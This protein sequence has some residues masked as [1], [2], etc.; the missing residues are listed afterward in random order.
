MTIVTNRSTL[1]SRISALFPKLSNSR[2]KLAR[3]VLD[4][5]LSVAF[6]SATE[7]GEQV[8]VS[9][10]TVVRFCQILGYEGYP[11]LQL[12]V[13]AGIP[14]YLRAVQRL[15]RG[16]GKVNQDELINRVFD[17][18]SQNI[19]RTAG[20]LSADRFEAAVVALSKASDIL[21]VGS[22]LS[23]APV[24]YLSHSLN[25]M[26]L[27]ARA[28]TDGGI[29]LA[30]EL[31]KLNSSSVLVAFSVWRYVAA[32]VHAMDRAA[33]AGAIRIAIS[34][35]AVSPLAQRADFAF[36]VAAHGAAHSL[37]ITA[38]MSLVNA[39]V[40]ALACARPE[41][42]AHALREIDSA[43]REGRLLIED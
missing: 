3:F 2:R 29:P 28:V 32:T 22:G 14:T 1:E 8:G 39:F 16:D 19:R 33:G 20:A 13:R 36:Q 23:A 26:G 6:A 37:S 43:Y 12:D 24:L 35:S 34:D 25:V 30:T 40:A 42:T 27:N 11:E 38:A 10:A 7:L 4:N 18:D 21:V 15:E 31:V 5:S 41:Q 17:L 9:A